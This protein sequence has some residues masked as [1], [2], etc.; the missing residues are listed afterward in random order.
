MGCLNET[1]NPA[2]LPAPWLSDCKQLQSL[3]HENNINNAGISSTSSSIIINNSSGGSD[4][5]I[6]KITKR[7]KDVT[8]MFENSYSVVVSM[9]MTARENRGARFVVADQERGE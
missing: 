4:H 9:P 8:G 2:Q 5:L 6:P 3:N 1:L 7:K